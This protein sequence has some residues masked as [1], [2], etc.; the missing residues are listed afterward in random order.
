MIVIDANEILKNKKKLPTEAFFI[1]TQLVIFYKDPFGQSGYNNQPNTGL[2]IKTREITEYLK[3]QHKSFSVLSTALEYYKFIQ[4]NIYLRYTQNKK[5]DPIDFKNL[6]NS[7]EQF[8][9]IWDIQIK[10]F[11]RLFSKNFPI[12][13]IDTFDST[14]INDFDGVHADFGDYVMYNSVINLD[15]KFRC[16]FSDDRDF[17]YFKGDFYLLT[18][19]KKVIELAKKDNKLHK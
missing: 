10:S 8:L 12:Y 5:F 18:F 14:N 9:S 1:D 6:K 16:I 19:N 3:S 15:N 4:V 11:K 13:P 7:N 2:N 17:Y